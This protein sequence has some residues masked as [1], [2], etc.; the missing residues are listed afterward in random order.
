MPPPPPWPPLGEELVE[1][2]LFRL[3][4]DDPAS[5]VR[6]A[7]VSKQWRRLIS[8]PG[9]RLPV[10]NSFYFYLNTKRARHDL[11]K[12]SADST[13][14]PQ[15]W[16]PSSST[17]LVVAITTPSARGLMIRIPTERPL[18]PPA[19]CPPFAIGR[20]WRAFD[21]RHGRVLLHTIS[22]TRAPFVVWDPI[23]DDHHE[24][25]AL[26]PLL[27]FSGDEGSWSGAVLCADAN[28]T[29]DHLD[30]CHQGGP[31]RVVFF[32]DQINESV[33]LY[34]L[35]RIRCLERAGLYSSATW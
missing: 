21:A 2:I 4:P 34:L 14:I 31:F 29:C 5:L 17:S 15:R 22:W 24:L 27:K 20:G 28:G 23:S 25:P 30:C 10:C 32:R 9:F 3:P 12:N 11:E 33:D 16:D 13:A 35:I 7:L 18:L 19:S 8:D 6:A 26:P 1:E